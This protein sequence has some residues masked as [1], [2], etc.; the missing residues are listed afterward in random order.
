MDP[1]RTKAIGVHRSRPSIDPLN[2][3]AAVAIALVTIAFPLAGLA[4]A[5]IGFWWIAR[6]IRPGDEGNE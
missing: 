4:L 2:L 6:T 1:H 5:A 3:A